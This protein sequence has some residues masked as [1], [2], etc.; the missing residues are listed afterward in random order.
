M[1]EKERLVS[2]LLHVQYVNKLE[3]RRAQKEI[4]SYTRESK[5]KKFSYKYKHTRR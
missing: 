1:M 4:E 3:K 2:K 5:V